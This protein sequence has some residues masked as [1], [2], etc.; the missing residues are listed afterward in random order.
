MTRPTIKSRGEY[1]EGGTR[2]HGAGAFACYVT[3]ATEY[4]RDEFVSIEYRVWDRG[5]WVDY[6]WSDEFRRYYSTAYDVSQFE[7]FLAS[8]EDSNDG[9]SMDNWGNSWDFGAL[10]GLQFGAVFRWYWY[11]GQDGTPKKR[12]ELAY[13][14]DAAKI[15]GA[16]TAKPRFSKDFEPEWK[17]AV[18]AG[19]EPEAEPVPF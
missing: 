10:E 13:T 14:L 7:R 12:P 11:V 6:E 18:E 3:K 19:R 17:A 1:S 2:Q 5:E 9:F 16:R 8:L 4:A 15:A